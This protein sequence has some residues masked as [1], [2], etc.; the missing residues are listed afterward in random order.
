MNPLV[1]FSS[2]SENTHRFVGRTG[3][4]AI[5]IP[6]DR[7]PE[8]LRVDLPYILV[9]P[10]YGGGSAKG[11]VPTQVI[12][13]LN[14]EHNRSLIRGVIAAGNTNFGAAYCIAG[15]IISQKCQVPYLYRFELLGT[16]EDV[17]KVRQGV[18]EFWQRQ[19]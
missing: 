19:N 2:S 10:S 8:K 3:L 14:D 12:R 6:T 9:V 13:F 15:D 11:A 7:Q 17:A 16:P 4:P 18:T 1:Y 5:R